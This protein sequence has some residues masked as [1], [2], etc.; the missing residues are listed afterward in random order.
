MPH[1]AILDYHSI[2][3]EPNHPVLSYLPHDMLKWLNI[4]LTSW[5]KED[6]AVHYTVGYFRYSRGACIIFFEN[7]EEAAYFDLQWAS[8]S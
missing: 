2:V 3:T 8:F 4:N 7:E 5:S 6:Q 1:R